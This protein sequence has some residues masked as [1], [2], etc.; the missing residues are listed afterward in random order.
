MAKKFGLKQAMVVVIGTP[1]VTKREVKVAAT[2]L[3]ASGVKLV[4]AEEAGKELIA[5]M[6]AMV[7]MDESIQ[8]AEAGL[9]VLDEMSAAKLKEIAEK[10]DASIESI[11]SAAEAKAG[12]V[13][14]KAE[15]KIV[16]L[17]LKI[18]AIGTKT[19]AQTSNI[20]GDANAKTA[21]VR[22][23]EAEAVSRATE[24][25]AIQMESTREMIADAK[26]DLKVAAKEIG[27]LG[28]IVD[29]FKF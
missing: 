3:K 9:V 20:E 12:K 22:R 26:A 5:K 7:A 10:T 29:L 1:D 8:A 11:E 15:R 4:V 23:Q 19:E 18:Q 24:N 14:E 27:V 25:F 28:R 17:Q 16:G 2:F 13:S 21:K 6:A